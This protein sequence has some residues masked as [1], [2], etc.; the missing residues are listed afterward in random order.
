MCSVPRDRD[1]R[2]RYRLTLS[3]EK[4]VPLLKDILP[5]TSHLKNRGKKEKEGFQNGRQHL[6]AKK[7]RIMQKNPDVEIAG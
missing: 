2:E 7:N 1:E 3:Q 5:S 6:Q 4:K